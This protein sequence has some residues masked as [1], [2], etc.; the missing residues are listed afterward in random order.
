[1]TK[2][3]RTKDSGK[4]Q[5]YSTGMNRDI[6]EGKPRFDL[7]DLA[8]LER[9]AGLMERGA[10]KYK[11]DNW[12]KAKTEEELRRFKASAFRHFIQWFRDEED[13]DH[14]AAVYF[15]IAGA[16]MV[17]EKLNGKSNKNTSVPKP[18]PTVH[19]APKKSTRTNRKV[20][21]TV[22]DG[23]TKAGTAVEIGGWYV[24][25]QYGRDMHPGRF[26]EAICPHGVGHHVGVHGC[27]GCCAH[28]PK[29]IWKHVS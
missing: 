11:E 29:E 18:V 20:A 17:K 25:P 22:P 4:R 3:F 2:A 23:G 15:N 1:M 16:E 6:Q 21:S 9:W 5:V 26:V 10:Q 13:E 27:D 28:P 12:R 7:V 14:A 8:M 24:L 19:A